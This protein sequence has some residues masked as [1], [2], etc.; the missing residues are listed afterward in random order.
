MNGH[1]YPKG[2]PGATWFNGDPSATYCEGFDSAKTKI[3]YPWWKKC[4]EWNGSSCMPKEKGKIMNIYIGLQKN[5][6]FLQFIT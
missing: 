2:C 6:T 5:C 1:N 4:C 3:V